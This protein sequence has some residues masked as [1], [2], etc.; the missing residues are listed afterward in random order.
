MFIWTTAFWL[1]FVWSGNVG[2]E[3]ENKVT[4]PK[5]GFKEISATLY[6]KLYVDSCWVIH[7]QVSLNK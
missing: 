2:N 3:R 5:K 4:F 1:Q 6:S 7:T